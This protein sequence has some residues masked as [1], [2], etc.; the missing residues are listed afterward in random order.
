MTEGM[1]I[2]PASM[3]TLGAVA[4]GLSDNLMTR[5]AQVTLKER[6]R[7][8]IVPREMPFGHIDLQNMLRISEAGGIV[9]PANPGFYLLPQKIGDLIDFVVAKLLDLV[10]V[11]HQLNNRWEGAPPA[12]DDA[13]SR[14][15]ATDP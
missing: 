15:S 9:C 14:D 10:H 7:L 11:P 5:A 3:N 12:L 13:K 4:A 2:V 8:I 1:I 6:R